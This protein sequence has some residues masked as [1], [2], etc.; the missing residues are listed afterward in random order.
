MNHKS[1]GLFDS[2]LGGYTIYRALRHAF[3]EVS[4]VLF[5]DQINNPYGQKSKE[6]LQEI[7]IEAMAWFESQDIDTV[8]IAC[9]TMSAVALDTMRTAFPKMTIIGIIEMTVSQV[10][11]EMRDV[12]VYG[13]S[14]TIA[15]N[16]YQ[17]LIENKQTNT[18]A[19][20]FA[21][22]T[23][24]KAIEK[25]AT[26]TEI[27]AIITKDFET[28]NT[29]FPLI[30]GC[31]H[32]PLVRSNIEAQYHGEIMDSMEPIL[33]YLHSLDLSDYL[34][35]SRLVTSGTPH[36]MQAQIKAL[37]HEVEQVQSWK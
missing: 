31:T 28:M 32:Y 14:A 17:S 25:Q 24:A 8:L 23:L 21:S 1:W 18:K 10:N 34:G 29:Q 27:N 26:D 22:A 2:G 11:L 3:P 12:N 20:G 19:H 5:A 36:I 9:N 15:S 13:T 37:F 7:A 33:T 35:P 30:L 16:A 6:R 4:F